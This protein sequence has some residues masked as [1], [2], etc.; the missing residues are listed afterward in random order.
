MKALYI[1]I[2]DPVEARAE[3]LTKKLLLIWSIRRHQNDILKLTSE[4][5]LQSRET[6][7]FDLFCP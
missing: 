4:Q 3:I 2:P 6:L 1:P 5:T 7:S